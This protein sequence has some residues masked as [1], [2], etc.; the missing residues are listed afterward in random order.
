MIKNIVEKQESPTGRFS[1]IPR[2][3]LGSDGGHSWQQCPFE[4]VVQ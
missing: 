1:S 3:A 4:V 2:K